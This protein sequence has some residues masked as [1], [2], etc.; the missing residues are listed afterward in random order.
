MG[1][2]HFVQDFV[3]DYR[4]TPERKPMEGGGG[5]KKRKGEKRGGRQSNAPAPLKKGEKSR[6]G[7][8]GRGYSPPS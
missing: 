7:K 6:R 1:N 3:Q 8:K 4:N 5:Q 2:A